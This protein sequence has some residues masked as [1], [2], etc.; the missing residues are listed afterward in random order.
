ME[1][2]NVCA[3]EYPNHSLLFFGAFRIKTIVEAANRH[4]NDK[5]NRSIGCVWTIQHAFYIDTKL[6]RFIF[7]SSNR[8]I[9]CVYLINMKCIVSLCIQ[10]Y[11]PRKRIYNMINLVCL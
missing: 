5:F 7:L 4:S 9:F 8:V 3:R 11:H 2:N 1:M 6:L 10:I